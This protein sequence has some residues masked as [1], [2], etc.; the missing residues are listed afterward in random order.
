MAY[1]VASTASM[2]TYGWDSTPT[3]S[4]HYYSLSQQPSPQ[5][6][7]QPHHQQPHLQ[8]QL[9]QD[10]TDQETISTFWRFLASS[11]SYLVLA[12]FLVLP[13]AFTT[14]SSNNNS[15]ND[16]NTTTPSTDPTT[17]IIA[18][19]VL[20]AIG[21][22][23]TLMLIFFQRHERQYLLHSIYIPNTTTSLLSLLNILL[24]I[25]CRNPT[26]SP[27]PL[28][29]VQTTSLV[30]PSVFAFLYALGALSIYAGDMCIFTTTTSSSSGG[31]DR[32]RQRKKG[33]NNQLLPLTEEEMQRQQLQRLLDQNSS[34][35]RGPSPRVVQKTFRVSAPER[36]NPGKGWDTFT[37]DLRVD[38]N[39][40]EHGGGN[41]RW[42]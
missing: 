42:V 27:G 40:S 30:L 20:I 5:P 13:L 34:P 19:S 3:L 15:N 8:L 2:S 24:N 28:S 11:S 16:E 9:Q 25:L 32:G 29:P 22:T 18:A 10:Q 26:Q 36:I 41:G 12:G 35:R 37:P 21:Y 23:I 33:K 4:P 38:G 14:T 1:T 31:G 39:G 6:S 17:T 7:P